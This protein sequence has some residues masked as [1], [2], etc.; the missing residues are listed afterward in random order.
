MEVKFQQS[1][2]MILLCCYWFMM[3]FHKFT[4]KPTSFYIILSFPFSF[5]GI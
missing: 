3:L 5:I 2:I 4:T 1:A